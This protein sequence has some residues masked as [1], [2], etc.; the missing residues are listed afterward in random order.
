[1]THSATVEV[2]RA[3]ALTTV[4]DLG[5]PGLAHLGVPRSGAL[6][7]AALRLANRLVGNPEHAAGLEITL[8]GCTLRLTRATTV[9]VTGAEV[10]VHAGVRPGDTGRPLSVPAGTVLRIGPARRGVRSWLAVAGGIDVPA[11]LGSRATDTLSGLGPPPLRDGDRLPLGAPLGT[12]AP[13][14]LTVSPAPTPELHLMLRPGPR[15]DWFTP[16]ALDR[17][18]GTAYTVS[19]VSNRVGARLAGAT[20]PRAVAGELP[21]EGIVLGAVQVPA[22]GQPLIF[23]AD[24]PTTGGYPVIGVVTD[25]TPLAQARP[26]TTVRFHGPQR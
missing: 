9:A 17:L 20:L 18:F 10:T 7:P 6:D 23:L 8:S 19:P 12:P 11:V 22:D 4:Q 14:D 15:D 2:L 3:G 5:R 26:G 24:H 16:T 13:V 1:M 21:S 25:V